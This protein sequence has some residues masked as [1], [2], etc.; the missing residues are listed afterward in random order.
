MP[1]TILGA[2]VGAVSDAYPK[3]GLISR[4]ASELPDAYANNRLCQSVATGTAAL[5]GGA[6]GAAPSLVGYVMQSVVNIEAVRPVSSAVYGVVR[7]CTRQAISQIG[8]RVAW[9][10]VPCIDGLNAG[11]AVYAVT[12]AA[13]GA[14]AP[15]VSDLCNATLVN[16]LVEA[17]DASSGKLVRGL[18]CAG[19]YRHWR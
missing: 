14:A 3:V 13:A 2:T 12:Q 18:L 17:V 10:E 1:L 9:D 19:V 8:P 5:V 15:L 7:D 11:A 16:A 6:F 4:V